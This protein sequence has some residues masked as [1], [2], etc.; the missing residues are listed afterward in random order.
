MADPSCQCGAFESPHHFFFNCTRYAAARTRYLPNNIN[1]YTSHG[2]LFGID[3]KTQGEEM[4]LFLV[5]CKGS[6]LIQDGLPE[7]TETSTK[8]SPLKSLENNIYVHVLGNVLAVGTH[9]TTPLSVSLSVSLSL[10]LSL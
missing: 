10:S 2:F 1:A 7:E 5:K 3:N 4:K 6:L 9:N 8:L